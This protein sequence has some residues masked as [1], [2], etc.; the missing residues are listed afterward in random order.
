MDTVTSTS[1]SSNDTNSTT[2]DNN[3]AIE[4]KKLPTSLLRQTETTTEDN[5]IVSRTVSSQLNQEQLNQLKRGFQKIPKFNGKDPS[6]WLDQLL[7]SI[8]Q[9]FLGF[10]TLEQL[11]LDTDVLKLQNVGLTWKEMQD[12]GFIRTNQK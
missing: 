6:Q 8:D 9:L 2:N 1:P 12:F 7:F 4:D 10:D 11:C 3:H 5:S